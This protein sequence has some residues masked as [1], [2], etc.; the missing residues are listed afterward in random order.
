S[1]DPSDHSSSTPLP[2]W[3][4]FYLVVNDDV[5]IL[6]PKTSAPAGSS[7]LDADPG[8]WYLFTAPLNPSNGDISAN[9]GDDLEGMYETTWRV[10]KWFYDIPRYRHYTGPDPAYPG[11]LPGR[12]FWLYH[13]NSSTKTIDLDGL[14]VDPTG[15]YYE[16][17]LPV[18]GSTSW[19]MAGNPYLYDIFWKDCKVR[20]PMTNTLPLAKVAAA[21]IES[22]YVGLQ[23]QSTDGKSLDTYNRAGIVTTPG[24]NASVLNAVDFLP[25]GSYIRL[26][27]KDPANTDRSALSYDYREAGKLEY[28]WSVELTTTYSSINTR[29]SVTDLAKV[30]EGYTFTLKDNASGEIFSLNADTTVPVTLTSATP[31]TFTL[32]ANAIQ[33]PIGVEERKP[34][35]FGITGVKPNPFNPS[36]SITF[37]ME[38]EGN[39]TVKIYTASGQLAAILENSKLSAGLH[40]VT[41]NASGHATGVYLAVVETKGRIDTRKITLMK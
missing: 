33:K 28:T 20:V 1:S 34:L 23:L 15:L 38:R 6:I 8:R 40:T 3:T 5:D 30:P 7:T 36:T 4:G 35:A 2:S 22:W 25:P 24:V 11:L 39:A 26:A 31:R 18:M 27:L 9:F 32:I 21:R 13:N 17:K 10:S 37:N 14:P 16:L 29:F 41:W 19:H 12:G